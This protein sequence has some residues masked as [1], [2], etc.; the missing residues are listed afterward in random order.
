MARLPDIFLNSYVNAVPVCVISH[1]VLLFRNVAPTLNKQSVYLSSCLILSNKENCLLLLFRV[2][3]N[4]LKC[5]LLFIVSLYWIWDS[6]THSYCRHWMSSQFILCLSA[7]SCTL[8][9]LPAEAVMFHL[10]NSALPQS[11]GCHYYMLVCRDIND[12]S[13]PCQLNWPKISIISYKK[14]MLWYRRF[15]FS[16]VHLVVNLLHRLYQ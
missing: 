6:H 16:V 5:A 12:N 13:L 11:C 15:L 2:K 4:T 10:T 3:L 14:S 1:R 7:C 8:W 9:S